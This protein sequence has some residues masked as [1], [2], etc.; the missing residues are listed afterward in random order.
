MGIMFTSS[1]EISSAALIDIVTLTGSAASIGIIHRVSIGQFSEAGDAEA[2]MQAVSIG[3]YTTVGSGGVANSTSSLVPSERA[4]DLG[5]RRGDTTVAT[6]SAVLV[7]DAWNLQAGWL[8]LPTPDERVI[9]PAVAAEGIY[10]RT[11]P[12]AD[13]VSMGCTIIWEEI[14]VT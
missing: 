1:F 8:Y 4:P 10:V 3:R 2:E 13:T 6:L 5:S 7:N 9:V 14:R 11:G 12:F